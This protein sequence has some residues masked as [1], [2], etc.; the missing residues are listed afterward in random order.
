MIMNKIF[1]FILFSFILAIIVGISEI[2]KADESSSLASFS[3]QYNGPTF[4]SFQTVPTSLD[5]ENVD[6]TQNEIV[7]PRTYGDGLTIDI[8]KSQLTDF[9]LQAQFI[10]GN[11]Q[12]QDISS[13]VYFIDGNQKLPLSIPQTIISQESLSAYLSAD[14]SQTVLNISKPSTPN[15]PTWTI[16][17]DVL[18]NPDLA[19]KAPGYGIGVYFYGSS[20]IA[21]SY[22][23]EIIWSLVMAPS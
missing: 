20:L 1:K 3:Y 6:P 17:S 4:P 15:L 21:G 12:I 23:G 11:Q 8:T 13:Q 7:Y 9:S 2:S 14:P 18:N 16:Q 10:Q 5:F 19:L 22:S